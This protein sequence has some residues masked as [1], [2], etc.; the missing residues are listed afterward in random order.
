MSSRDL[1]SGCHVYTASALSAEL[2][3]L[4]SGKLFLIFPLYGCSPA[5]HTGPRYQSRL[6]LRVPFFR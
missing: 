2:C 4:V 6:F 1:N 3:F 5:L